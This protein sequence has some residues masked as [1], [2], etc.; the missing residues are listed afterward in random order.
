[1]NDTFS[2]I[3]FLGDDFSFGIGIF[4]QFSHFPSQFYL[5]DGE[6][7]MPDVLKGS[8]PASLAIP[9][10]LPVR[11]NESVGEGSESRKRSISDL[12]IEPLA[13][14]PTAKRPRLRRKGPIIDEVTTLSNDDIRA[15]FMDTSEYDVTLV[16]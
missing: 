14:T 6:V 9:S 10:E 1:M 11:E 16:D 15:G 7:P 12:D 5:S 8:S 4:R 2:N 3:N 13:L